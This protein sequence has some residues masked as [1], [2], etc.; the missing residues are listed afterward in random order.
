MPT[1]PKR[2]AKQPAP[3]APEDD[4]YFDVANAR[5]ER[6]RD[7]YLDPDAVLPVEQGTDPEPPAA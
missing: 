5:Q 3:P 1:T 4:A 7:D 6:W 2:P